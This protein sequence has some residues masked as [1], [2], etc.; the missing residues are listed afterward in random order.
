MP[1]LKRLAAVWEELAKRKEGFICSQA[2]H[3]SRKI[4]GG[5]VYGYHAE[6][7][8]TASLGHSEG[9]HDFLVVEDRWL[10][11]FW[12]AAYYGERPIHDLTKDSAEILRLYGP[13]EK[14]E[15]VNC[16]GCPICESGGAH[17]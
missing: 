10:L 3:E 13:R 7:N 2:A 17:A 14:W 9:G 11:D 1:D 12:A 16:E 6:D 4:V 15:L 8:P 5:V